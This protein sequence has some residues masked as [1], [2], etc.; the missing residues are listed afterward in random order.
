MNISYEYY[1]IFYQV[2]R[3]GNITR[4]AAALQSNQ[5]NVSR[6][7][8]LLEAELGCTLFVR[9]RSGVQLTPEGERLFERVRVAVEQIEAGEEE[10]SLR[11]SLQNGTVSI[12]ASEVALHC[13]LLPVLKKY[14]SRYP[15]VR[16]SVN[17]NSTP[18]A[19]AS[20]KSGLADLAV[21][22][23]P[24]E[25]PDAMKSRRLRSVQE[26]AVCG[27]GFSHLW[28]R[29][30]TLDE[31]AQYPLICLSSCTQTHAFYSRLFM[32]HGVDFKPSVEAATADQIL[33]LVAS[34]LGIGFVPEV[35]LE[36]FRLAEDVRR[37]TIRTPIPP[38]WICMV[39]RSDF[40]FSIAARKLEEMLLDE[41]CEVQ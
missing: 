36:R 6:T 41:R 32:E 16:I 4:A 24:M 11:N 17:N 2:A 22:T 14:R 40:A 37:L 12:A 5:P 33:P 35:F 18:Q 15:A 26:V 9:S 38:R 7:I 19:I 31:L 30:L 23:T 29:A 3:Y 20:L 39:K 34:D 27:A 25:L 10:L 21:V 13:L 1:R 8:R 28:D